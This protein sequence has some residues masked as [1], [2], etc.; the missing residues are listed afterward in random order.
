[1]RFERFW[2]RVRGKRKGLPRNFFLQYESLSEQEQTS[3]ARFRISPDLFYPCLTDATSNTAFDRHYVYHPAWAMR[4]IKSINP[5]RHV[6]ISS[7][8]HFCSMLSAVVP[9]DFYDYRPADLVLDNLT[10]SFADITC[11]PFP[12]DSV[13]SLSCMHTVEHIGLGRYGDKL[14]YDGD[15]KAIFELKRV[16]APG[17]SLLFVVP[18][19]G[20]SVICFNAHRIYDKQQVLA[21]FSDMELMDFTLI[22]EDGADGGLVHNPSD[23]LLA[24]QFYG[25]G[26]FWFRKGATQ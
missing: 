7:T 3:N 13:L 11:L 16:I 20:E 25:C 8:L 12:D 19:G 21:L 4:I 14:D 24:K 5:D 6:D 26:C 1:M 17:G 9:T 23:A 15:L 2:S 18:L 22:P 10:S